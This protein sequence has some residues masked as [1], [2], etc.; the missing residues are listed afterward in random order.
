MMYFAAALALGVVAQTCVFWWMA[1][2]LR[3][4]TQID[5]RLASF[6]NALTL[7]TDT[8]E[9]CFQTLGG[10]LVDAAARPA[11]AVRAARQRRI[12]TAARRGRSV[13][14]IAAREDVAESEVRL[15]LT[16]HEDKGSVH[17][18]T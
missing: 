10:Q 17:G 15:R 12:V 13:G 7:L 2:R 16:L 8:T 18:T 6:A 1:A 4:L 9:T 5:D 11:P 3:R 14:D